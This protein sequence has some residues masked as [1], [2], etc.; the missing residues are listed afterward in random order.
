[1]IVALSR[2]GT[3]LGVNGQ[4]Q[5]IDSIDVK[6]ARWVRNLSSIVVKPVAQ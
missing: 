1:M 6:P 2:N 3:E 4:F 5:M